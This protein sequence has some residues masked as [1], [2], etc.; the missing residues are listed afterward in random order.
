MTTAFK[1]FDFALNNPVT[2]WQL[3]K[4]CD[5]SRSTI[6]NTFRD[7]AIE[8]VR[9][10]RRSKFKVVPRIEA[11][12]LVKARWFHE[13]LDKIREID[14]IA[15]VNALLSDEEWYVGKMLDA[16]YLTDERSAAKVWPKLYRLHD[17][18][19]LPLSYEELEEAA[20]CKLIPTISYKGEVY[21]ERQ[22]YDQ[23]KILKDTGIKIKY[24]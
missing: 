3:C 22:Y 23:L 6:Y 20:Y 10:T 17:E 5:V 9:L 19:L 4:D 21:V 24:Q 13:Y 16:N 14:V 12:K 11:W 15:N 18:G 7:L 1:L 2:V 8:R